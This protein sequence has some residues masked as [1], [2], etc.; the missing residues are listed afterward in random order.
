MDS[1]NKL[2][3]GC[4]IKVASSIKEQDLII[5]FYRKSGLDFQTQNKLDQTLLYLTDGANLGMFC[6]EKFSPSISEM[7]LIKSDKKNSDVQYHYIIKNIDKGIYLVLLGMLIHSFPEKLSFDGVSIITQKNSNHFYYISD[8]LEEEPPFPKVYSNL[9]FGI[10]YE[11]VPF[12]HLHRDRLIRVEFK[13]KLFWPEV[14]ILVSY[15]EA[16]HKIVETGGFSDFIEEAKES[17]MHSGEI[18]MFDPWTLEHTIDIFL[19][20]EEAFDALVNMFGRLHKTFC[21]VES[22]VIR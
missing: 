8:F 5:R 11:E 7:R 12:F 9:P 16:W 21:P 4:E 10:T 17:T 19:S 3:F 22:I 14:D 13:R 15:L 20:A 2:P 1:I 18:Y 6:G